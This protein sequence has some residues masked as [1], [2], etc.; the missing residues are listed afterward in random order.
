MTGID[1][2]II[3]AYFLGIVMVGL[4][5]S[6]RAAKG[7][8]AY[9]LGGNNLPWW[10]LAAS[11]SASNYDV[12]GTMFLVSLFYVAGLRS[13]WMLWSWQFMSAAFLMAYM[14]IW[15]RRTRVMTAVE[16][17]HIRFGADAG[18]RMARSAGAILMV[19]FLVFSIG[20]AFVGISKFLP[21][22]IPESVPGNGQIWA[23]VLMTLTT[24]YVTAGGFSGVV[25]TDLIQ[26]VL[27]S[28]A[29][30][31]VGVVVF[32]KLDPEMLQILHE[33]FDINMLPQAKLSMPEGYEDWNNFGILC[34]FWFFAGLLLNTSG[35]GGHYQEQRFL[36]TRSKAD[37]ARV[38]CAWGLFLVP[39]WMMIAGFC[40]V[41]AS[42]MVG[43]EDPEQILPIVLT[44]MIPSGLRG[45]VLA[46]LM[47]AF[48]STFSSVINAAASMVVR[49]LIHPFKPTLSDKSQV[50]LSYLV[51]VTAVMLG[52]V[53]GFN[54]ETIRSIWTW[55]I[56]GLIGGSLIPNVLR[57]HWW[58]LNGWGYS[59]GIFMGL[60]T[61][62]LVK[63]NLFWENPP[64]Y[65]YAPVVWAMTLIGCVLG[66]L[67]TEP[68]KT[69]TL[70]HFY[71]SVRPY[72]FWRPI[73]ARVGVDGLGLSV[74]RPLI[75]VIFNVIVGVVCLTSS[76]V[77]TFFVIGHYGKESIITVSL[78]VT[79][80][81]VLYF[82]W[83]RPLIR[84]EKEYQKN[85]CF[86]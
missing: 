58:R 2:G 40:F 20:Y 45:L 46:A 1:I 35:A 67:L 17:L 42:G 68:T 26:A 33:N 8:R 63:F 86:E 22:I 74:D 49:D 27:M 73:K 62:L 9:F 55:M 64:E 6:R 5:F 43:S 61:A 47:A 28:L 15:I 53:I 16:L 59:A 78:A 69:E 38:G 25:I 48:M 50:R 36:A 18:G 79:S 34:L 7:M 29:G 77:S 14:A 4:Y 60:I 19:T 81:I 66:S 32:L 57:W 65:L 85:D 70:D 39:R 56:I 72:G 44:E 51:T 11:G 37:A 71:K 23:I 82:N 10:A 3:V 12:T 54:A 80:G 31:L 13:F 21:H 52:I 41:A 75:R 30:I 76:F 24:F 83:Y 84:S